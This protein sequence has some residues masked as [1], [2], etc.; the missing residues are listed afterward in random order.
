MKSGREKDIAYIDKQLE[1][2]KIFLAQ[3][4]KRGD[5]TAVCNLNNKIMILKNI[6]E[7]LVRNDKK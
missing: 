2:T 1:K 6:R 5:S 4:K 3:A 7:V